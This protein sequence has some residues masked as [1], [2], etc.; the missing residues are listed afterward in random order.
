MEKLNKCLDVKDIKDMLKKSGELY[1]E[2]PAYKLR[3][4]EPNT[5]KII[6]HK[7][8][9]EMVDNLGTELIDLK[10]KNKRIAVIGENRYEWE[11]AYLAVAAGTGIIVPLDKGLPENELECL[12]ERSEVEAIFYSEKY[13][14]ILKSISA[15]PENKLKHLISMDLEKS[16]DGIFSQKELIEKG[17]KLIENG[18][19]QFINCEIDENAMT[20]MLFTSGTTSQSKA[21]MLS[22]KNIMTNL[23]DIER[24]LDL[25]C[26]DRMLSFLPVHHVF[27]CTVGFLL[28]L[29]QGM[30]TSFCDGIRH[31]MDNVREY[32]TTFLICVPALYETVYAGIM[33]NFEKQGRLEEIQMK[34]EVTKNWSLE[35]KREV[36]K[37]VN[38][39]FG[40]EM[41]YLVSGAAS[42]NPVVEEAFRDFG[43]NFFQ[44][45]G[46]TE[47]APVVSVMYGAKHKI[48]SVGLAMPSLDVKLV[49]KNRKGIGE[50]C[51]KGPNVMLGY[52]Q[53]EDAT[54]EAIDEDGWFHTGDL[55]KLDEDGYI[56]IEGRKKNVIVL[57]NGKN[58]FPEEMEK[59]IN[60]IE[61]VKESMIF[62]NS[63]KDDKKTNKIYVEIVYDAQIMEHA[64][65]V[66][67][68]EEIYDALK[69]KIKE[70]N[71][72]IPKYKAI[73]EVFLTEENI[74]K[75]TTG[76]IKRY[77]ELDKIS[78]RITKK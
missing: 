72:E 32:K 28:C 16:K 59:L 64:Y 24:V 39:F 13:E 63:L 20:V 47:T 49:E 42:L 11:V 1:A 17:K 38:N 50:L 18:N 68:Q 55:C 26:E 51:V 15:K 61:G 75:T 22:H 78:S 69:Q 40:G 43:I 73:R 67:T 54:N 45:Y 4:E 3:G 36:F 48:G 56:F 41:K 58:I 60:K 71:Q 21:V 52:Y 9:R 31:I 30:S 10:L 14:D 70:L 27:E 29:Y 2:R 12:I 25:S 7:Q 8:V 65:K 76:K 34:R 66:N 74:E 23:M 35:E 5:Y 62:G 53:N 44:G 77:A 57:K 33:K 6:T 46:L 19:T 37:E